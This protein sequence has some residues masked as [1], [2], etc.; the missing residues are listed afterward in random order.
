MTTA[1]VISIAGIILSA[2][3][4]YVEY[5]VHHLAE[6]EEF[7]AMCDIEAISASC[8]L[9][10]GC[11]YRWCFLSLCFFATHCAYLP[12]PPRCMF[13]SVFQLPQGHLISYF[14]LVSEDHV[15]NVPNAFLGLLYYTYQ[16]ILRQY[17]PHSMTVMIAIAAMSSS[18]FLAY[19]LTLLKELCILCWTTHVLN[20]ILLYD[21]LTNKKTK[22][23]AMKEKTN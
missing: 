9:V 8:R 12:P 17:M 19:H 14:G 23:T 20:A 13:S 11:G 10:F 22:H 1:S 21:T 18:V 15:M 16:L 3:A 6:G 7:T 5:K 4:L 2:Y